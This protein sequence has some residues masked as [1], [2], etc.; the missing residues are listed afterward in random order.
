MNNLE[1]LRGV[2]MFAGLEDEHMRLL[3]ASLGS[4]AFE[5]G[6]MIFHQGSVGNTLYL[7]VRGQVRIY[8]NSQLGQEISVMLFR[9][10]DFFGELSLLDGHERSAS[11]VAMRA[12]TTLTLH[13]AAFLQ[14]IR[15][16]PEIAVTVLEQLSARLRHTNTYIEHLASTSAPQRVIRTLL[17]LADQHGVLEQG[18]T[19]I[20]LHLTQDDLASLAGTTRETVNRVLGG[21]RDQGLI[22]IERARLSVL[23]LAQLEMLN[24]EL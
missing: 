14:A 19:R 16:Y 3:S 1:L 20:D 13:R 7:I 5:R 12:T 6:A 4:Q 23:N 9:D 24:V 8:T 17:D 15:T 2:P 22:H 10:G 18:T 21:L 11:A